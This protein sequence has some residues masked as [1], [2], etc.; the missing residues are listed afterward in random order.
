MPKS[1]N[2][3]LPND[4]QTEMSVDMALSQA[5]D[6]FNAGRYSEADKLCTAIIQTVPNHVVAINI[7]GVI[8]QK[9]HR[10]GLAVE[11]FQRAIDH[12]NSNSLLFYNLGISL[13]H[14]GQRFPGNGF[15]VW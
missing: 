2:A 6:H 13:F 11:L 15:R 5:I 14:A 7:L 12:D 4:R 3:Q 8:A 1:K 9:A 10:H